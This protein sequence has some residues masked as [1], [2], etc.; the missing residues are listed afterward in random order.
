MFK[1]IHNIRLIIEIKLL[2]LSIF[3]GIASSYAPQKE[4]LMLHITTSVLK[5][6]TCK[7]YVP[8]NGGLH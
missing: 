8:V 2:K 6:R 7:S 5:I 3:P 1:N 4:D